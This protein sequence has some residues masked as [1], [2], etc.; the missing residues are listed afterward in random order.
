MDIP[1]GW[2]IVEHRLMREFEFTDFSAAKA[3][4][5]EISMLSEDANHHPEIH[6]GWGYVVIELYTHDKEK[7]TEKDLALAHSINETM[8]V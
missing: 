7:I 1:T 8:E 3:F 4:V 5:D 6:L 2:A